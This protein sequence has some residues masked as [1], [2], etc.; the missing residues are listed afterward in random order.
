MV[1]CVYVESS[2]KHH[3]RT[4]RIL[5]RFK[6]A[7]VVEIEHHGEVFNPSAQ[8][9]R[10]QKSN[11]A[12]ILAHKNNR[13]A[14]PTPEGYGLG[15]KHNFY[16]SHMLNCLYDCRYCFLQGMY[17]SAHQVIFI[18]YEDFDD[19]ITQ[20]CAQHQSEPVW[21]FSGYDCDSLAYEPVTQFANF[22]VPAFKKIDNA[23]LEL[24]TK[25]TQV[26]QLLKHEPCERIITA[27]SFTEQHSHDKL[28]HGVPSI[29]KRID[30]MRLLVEAGWPI[31]LRFDPIVYHENYQASFSHLLETIFSII[32]PNCLH[33]VSLGAFRLP[34][35]NFRQVNKLYPDE[36]LFH[37]NL[38][39][40]NGIV[41]Y[42]LA[43]EEEMMRYCEQQLLQHIPTHCYQPC[44]WHE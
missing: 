31:G 39:L 5:A 40:D 35:N 6:N 33:S 24:R 17:N 29:E 44:K 41:G 16:F 20:I 15:G 9:F 3:E 14:L 7:P 27:F 36:S 32:D 19:D 43:Q 4:L 13:H 2:V 8:N 12:L 11:P 25:S 37:Q 30:A 22:F 10:L 21:F 38:V 42:P 23:W 28:E 1:S 26:R 18:N 34:K